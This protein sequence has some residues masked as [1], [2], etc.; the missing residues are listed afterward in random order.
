LNAAA[1]PGFYGGYYESPAAGF[2]R[3]TA[4]LV[5]A[6]GQ[7]LINQQQAAITKEQSR[8][9]VIKTRRQNFD[10][11][12]Y[13]R[14]NTPTFEDER[15]HFQAE[16]LRRSR[17]APLDEIWSGL[18]LNE[19]L[20]STQK[21]EA[22]WP[23]PS[24]PLDAGVVKDV[25]VTGGTAGA[26]VGVLRDGGRLQW[27][28]A[29]GGSAYAAERQDLTELTRQAV[30]QAAN[31]Q[32]DAD[33]IHGMTDAVNRLH[34][35]IKENIATMAFQDYSAAK[36]FLREMEDAIR[37]LQTP[38]AARYV[39]GKWAARGSTIGELVQDMTRQGLRF[40]PATAGG[41]AAYVAVHRALAAYEGALAALYG[42][43]GGNPSVQTRDGQP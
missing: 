33:T 18:A 28:V 4:D 17:S 10:E 43:P 41:E 9:E 20:T 30:R 27:P 42:S 37:V 8:Q 21:M 32:V 39:S 19:L 12:L 36:R 22:K 31:G 6:Q 2:L 1:Y 11:Y 25:N 40:A 34:A 7:W 24:I 38:N 16:A 26:G 14:Q 35:L 29:L 3:G 23:G 13:E 15:S 5:S